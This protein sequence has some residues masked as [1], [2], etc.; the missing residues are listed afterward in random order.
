MVVFHNLKG[1]LQYIFNLSF[2][3]FSLPAFFPESKTIDLCFSAVALYH[4]LFSEF[5][6]IESVPSILTIFCRNVPIIRYLRLV[7]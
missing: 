1:V 4:D 5:D 6:E 2:N 3:N 7:S